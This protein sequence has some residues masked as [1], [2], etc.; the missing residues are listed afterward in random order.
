MTNLNA[1]SH[2]CPWL[3]DLPPLSNTVVVS[4]LSLA[5]NQS[6]SRYNITSLDWE[7][8]YFLCLHTT[9]L[10][11][12]P[13]WHASLSMRLH[14]H[15]LLIWVSTQSFSA[16]TTWTLRSQYYW[17]AYF[18]L[19]SRSWIKICKTHPQEFKN[20]TFSSHYP[21]VLPSVFTLPTLGS[22][23]CYY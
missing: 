18:K 11:T 7:R 23:P 4:S 12:Y 1:V 6:W 15:L 5:S 22:A 13:A 8:V 10:S 19:R 17:W 9:L 2:C 3:Y 21:L 14:C 20:N 16:V